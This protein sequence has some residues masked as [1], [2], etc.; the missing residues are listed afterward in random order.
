MVIISGAL[1]SVSLSEIIRGQILQTLTKYI[2][3][4]NDPVHDTPLVF[5]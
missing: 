4:F 5:S 3:L 1:W 2:S